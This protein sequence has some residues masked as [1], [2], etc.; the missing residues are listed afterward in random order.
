V[1]G[2]SASTPESVRAR[3]SGSRGGWGA[4][5]AGGRAWKRY[6]AHGSSRPIRHRQKTNQ[7]MDR[8]DLSRLRSTPQ[9]EPARGSLQS[10]EGDPTIE[11]DIQQMARS[12]AESSREQPV[13]EYGDTVSTRNATAR[14][15]ETPARGL[16]TA[17]SERLPRLTIGTQL[18]ARLRAR[19]WAVGEAVKVVPSP[20]FPLPDFL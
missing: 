19:W 17:P 4:S 5:W 7:K 15:Y 6:R 10:V 2:R 16:S 12:G 1:R 9:P 14:E 3:S 8:E 13:R 18:R 20:S 11:R